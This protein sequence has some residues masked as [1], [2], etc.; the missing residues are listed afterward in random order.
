MTLGIGE[1][2]PGYVDAYYGPPEWRDAAKAAP[3]SV[4]DLARA[5]TALAAR[6]N[7]V[8]PVTLEPLEQRRR[9]FLMAQLKAA[10]TRRSMLHGQTLRYPAER[11]GRF[12]VRPE[13]RPA[14]HHI[15]L[16]AGNTGFG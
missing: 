5:A 9:A 11:E 10:S 7:A 3:R 13:V 16:L 1:R 2:E 14:Q 4:E 6:V 8:D 12:V 15:P